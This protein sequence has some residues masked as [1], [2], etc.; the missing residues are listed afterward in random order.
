MNSKTIRKFFVVFF[1]AALGFFRPSFVEQSEVLSRYIFEL[2]GFVLLLPALFLKKKSV[3]ISKVSLVGFILLIGSMFSSIYI[4]WKYSG[5]SLMQ[6]FTSTLPYMVSYLSL[7]LMINLN[8]NRLFLERVVKYFAITTMLIMAVNLLTSTA[9]FGS[10]DISESRGGL[11]RARVPGIMTIA[12]FLFYS[13]HRYSLF[14]NKK[15]IKWILMCT[16]FIVLSLTRQLILLCLAF[17]ILLYLKNAKLPQKIVFIVL[18][19]IFTIIVLPQLSVFKNLMSLTTEQLSSDDMED[20]IRLIAWNYYTVEKQPDP[21]AYFWGSGV[22]NSNSRYGRNFFDETTALK[23]YIV[24]IGFGGFYYL[25]GF[26][27]IIGVVVLLCSSFLYKTFYLFTYVKFFILV[28]ILMSFTSGVILNRSDVV[29]LMI[30]IYILSYKNENSNTD[31]K[32]Q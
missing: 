19:G 16:I 23:V 26:L 4:A 13:I 2:V 21:S 27:G 32:L 7:F 22:P 17:G 25:F 1:L 29:L 31:L 14:K 3:A 5:Q 6:G 10:I 28:N 8:I 20:N 11:L 15:H 24:D 18:I 9:L 12:F 30:S